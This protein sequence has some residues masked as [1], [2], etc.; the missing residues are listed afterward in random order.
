VT[1]TRFA[2]PGEDWSWCS[3]D[4]IAFVVGQEVSQ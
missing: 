2:E 3:I 4:E 1:V